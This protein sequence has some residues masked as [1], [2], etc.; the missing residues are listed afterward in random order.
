MVRIAPVDAT[1]D[2]GGVSEARF[3][4]GVVLAWWIGVPEV[5][6]AVRLAAVRWRRF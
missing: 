3:V 1:V 2:G 5:G 6:E 4:F